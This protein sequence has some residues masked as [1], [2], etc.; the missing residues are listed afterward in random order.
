M[1]IA[2]ELFT[3]TTTNN[4]DNNN[5]NNDSSIDEYLRNN[6]ISYLKQFIP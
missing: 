5:D 1:C 3:P 4:D 2:Y 6:V